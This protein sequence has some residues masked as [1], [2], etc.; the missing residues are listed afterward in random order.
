MSKMRM[1][2]EKGWKESVSNGL[3]LEGVSEL[4][5][6]YS[7]NKNNI[8]LRLRTVKTGSC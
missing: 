8:T 2:C 7:Q 4:L 1:R 6:I 3:N 5:H